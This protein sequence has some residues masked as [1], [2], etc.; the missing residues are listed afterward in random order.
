MLNLTNETQKIDPTLL[1]GERIIQAL[2]MQIKRDL[3][4]ENWDKG[5]GPDHDVYHDTY[6]HD[7]NQ[8]SPWSQNSPWPRA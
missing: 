5:H 4:T 8:G 1:P 2:E 7:H 6:Y 3:I